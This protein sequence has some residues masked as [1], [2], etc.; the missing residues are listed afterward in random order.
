MPV[1]ED[2]IKMD[3]QYELEVVDW[4]Y[5]TFVKT[6]MKL[7][8][9]QNIVNF[10]ASCSPVTF[11]KGYCCIVPVSA[12]HTLMPIRDYSKQ[13]HLNEMQTNEITQRY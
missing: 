4:I 1:A 5:L 8:L 6:E 10:L 7:S 11:H 9:L 2:D 3:L 12:V 13:Q